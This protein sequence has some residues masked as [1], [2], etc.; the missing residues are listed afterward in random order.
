MRKALVTGGSGYI[1]SFLLRD[2][3]ADHVAVT[4]VIRPPTSMTALG[5]LPAL[6]TVLYD[7]TTARMLEIISKEKPDVVFHLAAVG[8]ADHTAA[9][10]ERMI[11]ANVSLGTQVLEGL[12]QN[13]CGAFVNTGTFWQHYDG[14]A[15]YGPTS[16]YAATKQAFEDILT[17]YT[18]AAGVPAITLKLFDVYGP[19]DIRGRLFTLLYAAQQSGIPLS[20]SPGEQLLDLVYIDDVIQAYRQAARLLQENPALS[21]GSYAVSSGVRHAL[22]EA[23]SVFEQVSGMPVPVVWGGRAYRPREIMVPWKGKS[24]PGWSPKVPLVQGLRQVLEQRVMLKNS[25]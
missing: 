11:Q 9:D 22:R 25:G 4:A 21:G 2:L 15:S 23:V 3:L 7:G 12:R 20:L 8:G 1:G 16:L 18:Q 6:R 17:Y 19:H 13:G 5:T 24:L 10:L 14:S